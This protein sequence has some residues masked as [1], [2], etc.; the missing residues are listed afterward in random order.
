MA[1]TVWLA[2]GALLGAAFLR[3]AAAGD[4]FRE[5]RVL[6]VGL[7]VAAGVYAVLASTGGAGPLALELAGVAL[8]AVPAY[9]GLRAWPG[10]LAAGWAAHAVWD[11]AL[12]LIGPGYGPE[13]Y[14]LLCLG[15]DPV[16][17]AAVVLRTPYLRGRESTNAL[18]NQG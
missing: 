13:P 2:A 18:V 5:R 1:A 9:A 3:F 11:G 8:F 14:A 16:V 4:A 17:A 7:V 10:W 15:F 6:A 12:H